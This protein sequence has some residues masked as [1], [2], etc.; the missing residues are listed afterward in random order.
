[1]ARLFPALADAAFTTA[2]GVRGATPDGLPMVGWSTAPGVLLAVGARR[3]GW[4]LAP[5]VARIVA[6]QVTG[7]DAGAYA[8]RLE[9]GRF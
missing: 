6:A 1:A 2:A 9:P 7:A 8:A 3:N 5:L 4:L